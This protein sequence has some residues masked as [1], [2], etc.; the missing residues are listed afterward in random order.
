M[1]WLPL[2]EYL[3]QDLAVQTQTPNCV[4]SSPPASIIR[5][6]GTAKVQ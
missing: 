6:N 4:A 5:R 3:A 2:R 1:T